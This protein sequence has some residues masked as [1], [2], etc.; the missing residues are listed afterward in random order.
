MT[1]YDQ[2]FDEST[3]YDLSIDVSNYDSVSTDDHAF[4]DDLKSLMKTTVDTITNS[5]TQAI[6]N[7]S[8]LSGD[9]AILVAS[10]FKWVLSY[11]AK[12][13]ED[14]I[15]PRQAEEK[16]YKKQIIQMQACQAMMHQQFCAYAS[17]IKAEQ[18]KKGRE[19]KNEEKKDISL[20]TLAH[21]AL[22]R[23]KVL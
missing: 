13:T 19:N 18:D 3:T 4:T 14:M 17:A 8:K 9:D 21:A 22:R 20:L 5:M 23:K 12:K 1:K 11:L 10:S 16:M 15:F 2:S 7:V 6:D